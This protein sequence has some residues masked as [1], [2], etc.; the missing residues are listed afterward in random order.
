ME[1]L[2]QLMTKMTNFDGG[3]PS[4]TLVLGYIIDRYQTEKVTFCLLFTA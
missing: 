4:A 1:G 2:L 3:F